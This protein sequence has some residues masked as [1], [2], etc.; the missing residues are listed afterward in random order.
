M[1]DTPK[2]AAHVDTTTPHA[3]AV[4]TTKRPFAVVN[5]YHGGKPSV[6]SGVTSHAFST[7]RRGVLRPARRRRGGRRG[8]PAAPQTGRCADPP[9][10]HE[11]HARRAKGPGPRRRDPSRL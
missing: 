11:L 7:V 1:T 8:R 5:R 9:L 10:P 4:R 2:L 6:R 3:F